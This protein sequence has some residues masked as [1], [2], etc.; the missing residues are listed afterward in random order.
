M[1]DLC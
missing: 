1:E